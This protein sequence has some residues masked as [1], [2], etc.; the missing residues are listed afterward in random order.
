[1]S[2]AVH[3]VILARGQE[4]TPAAP[5]ISPPI[6]KEKKATWV[7]FADSGGSGRSSAGLELA[8]EVEKRGDCAILISMGEAF[9]DLES[10]R[11]QVRPL[12]LRIY[13]K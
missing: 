3:S 4:L 8:A 11:F 13:G 7:I 10:G 1:M 6:Q 12:V 9:R 2:N 5:S